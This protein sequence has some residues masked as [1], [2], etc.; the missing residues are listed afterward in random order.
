MSFDPDAA[1][2][3]LWDRWPLVSRRIDAKHKAKRAF[4]TYVTTAEWCDAIEAPLEEL[5]KAAKKGSFTLT[6][7]IKKAAEK[8]CAP[9]L[10]APQSPPRP[11]VIEESRPAAD[12]SNPYGDAGPADP[13]A[14][15]AFRR[16]WKIWPKNDR[17]EREPRARAAFLEA[18][19][20]VPLPDVVRGCE[21]YVT[22]FNDPSE[23]IP[24]PYHLSTFLTQEG[25]ALF[26]AWLLRADNQVPPADLADFGAA[27]AW[28]PSHHPDKDLKRPRA[29]ALSLYLRL[30]PRALRFD[31]LCAVKAYRECRHDEVRAAPAN[32][33]KD[34]RQYTKR[35]GGFIE[36][37]RLQRGFPE[38]AGRAVGG[39]LMDVLEPH[40]ARVVFSDFFSNSVLAWLHRHP[41]ASLA[42]ATLEA[43]RRLVAGSPAWDGTPL[44]P[45]VA[46][47]LQ[48]AYQ[49]ACVPP[50]KVL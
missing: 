25:G 3:A 50:R 47:G 1:F 10:G 42:D 2:E 43:A 45:L 17:P 27:Y 19:R 9:A 5:A 34:P 46:A 7:A 18:V 40:G 35:F 32:A 44:E 14:E 29:E 36:G 12:A 30:V 4:D 23:A 15:E 8:I 20:Q 6:F 24:F 21:A 13:A 26:E 22:A 31:F 33:A 16:V 41:E 37:W 38:H 39:P 48:N 49:R 28:Y 11:V